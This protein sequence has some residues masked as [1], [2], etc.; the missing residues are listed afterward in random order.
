MPSKR[1]SF[2]SITRN[3]CAVALLTSAIPMFDVAE[4]RAE[5]LPCFGSLTCIE[6]G[7]N[8]EQRNWWYSTTQGSRL[9]PYSWYKALKLSDDADT[10]FSDP[11]H[12]IETL[13]YL[14]NLRDDGGPSNLPLGFAIDQR[15]GRDAELMCDFFPAACA[16]GLMREAWL[17]MTCSACHTAEIT[18]QGKRV[19]VEG[20]PA[21]ADFQ[22]MQETL[23]EA[24]RATLNSDVRFGAF[25]DEVLGSGS[26][27]LHRENLRLMLGEQLDWHDE[28]ATRNNDAGL[29]YG[30]GRLDA[31]GHILTKVEAATGLQEQPAPDDD[32]LAITQSDAPAS[33]PHLWNTS[34]Q[35]QIQWNGIS[36]NIA[37]F[38]LFGN[39]TDVGALVRNTSQ[40]IGV[41]A[42]MEVDR[43]RAW[44]GYR[45][46]ARVANLVGL[47]RQLSRLKSPRWPEDVLGPIDRASA[48]RGREL[49]E[50]QGCADCHAPLAWDDISSDA[51]EQMHPISEQKTDIFLA[52]NTFLHKSPAGNFENQKVFAFLGDRIPEYSHT[53]DMLVNATVG[54]ITGKAGE[55]IGSIFRDVA[56]TGVGD[57]LQTLTPVEYLPG[58]SDPN[59]RAQAEL[60]LTTRHPLLAYKARPLNGIW[61]TAPYLHNGSVPTLYDL[62][63]PST[64]RL[65]STDP[66]VGQDG[67]VRPEV[68]GVGSQ[69]FD[70]VKVGFVQS[71]DENPFVFRVRDPDTSEPIPGNFNSGHEYGTF[72]LTEQERLDLVE[73]MKTL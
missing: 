31:Q 33:Y 3:A 13:G 27:A 60:C 4:A 1:L 5:T 30:H 2:A 54:V 66:L 6:Q 47:E 48:T 59:K 36:S 28:L 46:S 21:L 29:R 38:T 44:Q 68:F 24:M 19:R 39:S 14:E 40:V 45:S 20:A 56:P 41:F 7:W 35:V 70:P 22:A 57:R 62:L 9:V 11:E 32:P 15:G 18:H 42:H 65:A 52:C 72:E 58:V 8:I 51:G 37:Q 73:Y 25:A 17:G 43:G 34:Q 55:F 10:R 61:A 63:L 53:R 50:R 71:V 26:D 69:E 67:P 49:F 64:V 16:G 23:R 12:M